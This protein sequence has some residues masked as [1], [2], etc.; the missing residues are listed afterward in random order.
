MLVLIFEKIIF[1]VGKKIILQVVLYVHRIAQE[2]I[3][4]RKGS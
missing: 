4:R 1:F 3:A 2:S